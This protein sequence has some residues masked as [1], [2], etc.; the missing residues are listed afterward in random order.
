M[1]LTSFLQCFFVLFFPLTFANPIENEVFLRDLHA[2]PHNQ[3]QNIYPRAVTQ[4]VPSSYTT[5]RSANTEIAP[6]P[7]TQSTESMSVAPTRSAN[8]QQQFSSGTG[9]QAPFVTTD[10]RSA[11]TQAAG[12]TTVSSGFAMPTGEVKMEV[13]FGAVVVAVAGAI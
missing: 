10:S 8:T 9:S 13:V 3:I 11:N 12:P 6:P 5:S 1:L 4:L 2:A 7:T